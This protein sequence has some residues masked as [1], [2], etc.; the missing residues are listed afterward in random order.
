MTIKEALAKLT[1]QLALSLDEY[2]KSEAARTIS[3]NSEL[4]A[5]LELFRLPEI[6][7]L[8]CSSEELLEKYGEQYRTVAV[9]Y[10]DGSIEAIFP[11]LQDI[12]KDSDYFINSVF[13]FASPDI[14]N[15][16]ICAYNRYVSHEKHL[17]KSIKDKQED[18]SRLTQKLSDKTAEKERCEAELNEL[19]D[20]VADKRN[21]LK[22]HIASCKGTLTKTQKELNECQ[23]NIDEI[24]RESNIYAEVISRLSNAF[25]EAQKQ[26]KNTATH[27]AEARQ[28]AFDACDEKKVIIDYVQQFWTTGSIPPEMLDG[29]KQYNFS[30]QLITVLHE[31]FSDNAIAILAKLFENG[32][33]DIYD[34]PFHSFLSS[35]PEAVS[36]FFADTFISNYT[37]SADA[38]DSDFTSWLD[39][40]IDNAFPGSEPTNQL[41]C[42]DL[43]W[44]KTTSADAWKVIVNAVIENKPEMFHNCIAKIIL[45]S[46]GLARKQLLMLV[47]KLVEDETID[48]LSTLITALIENHVPGDDAPAIVDYFVQRAENEQF[49]LRRNNER[50]S[51]KISH[52]SSDVYGALSGALESL[53][54]LASNLDCGG[55][56]IAPDL[57]ASKLKKSL[58]SLREGLE[59]AGIGTIENASDWLT[60]KEIAFDVEKHSIAFS[61]P[62]QKVYLR[63]LGFVYTDSEGKTKTVPAKVGRLQELSTQRKQNKPKKPYRTTTNQP[64]SG[65]QK[66]KKANKQGTRKGG[67]KE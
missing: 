5:K 58:I 38:D 24:T 16:F 1:T 49:S 9:Y 19:P 47:Q 10:N 27:F 6:T 30:Q 48:S 34:E 25:I 45:R 40:I 28:A 26:V 33:I 7:K 14:L 54:T 57:I 8:I 3:N 21:E 20:D 53:E 63:T 35:H 36:T 29:L 51:F 17:K 37:A 15:S 39:F 62:P 18:H 11:T 65:P 42:Y 44:E 66:Y 22:K 56:S 43:I 59:V 12:T 13:P 2:G 4:L 67:A 41:C 52:F 23:H 31:T 50:M 46:A 60:K 32:A 61:T 55:E 64:K